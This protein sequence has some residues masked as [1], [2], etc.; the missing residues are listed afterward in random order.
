MI[1]FHFIVVSYFIIFRKGT[2]SL[3]LSQIMRDVRRSKYLITM[4][5][6]LE[7]REKETDQRNADVI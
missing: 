1:N 3:Y 4:K 7:K 5:K 6:F 2:F